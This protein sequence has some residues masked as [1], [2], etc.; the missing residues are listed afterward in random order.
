MTLAVDTGSPNAT[1]PASIDQSVAQLRSGARRLVTLSIPQRSSIIDRCIDGVSQVASQW[2]AAACQAKR[3]PQDSSAQS[4]EIIAGPFSTLRYL[5]LLKTTLNDIH[6][7]GQPQLPGRPSS[8]AG[9]LRVPIFPTR[10]LYDRLLFNPIQAETWIEPGVPEDE[11]F[12]GPATQLAGKAEP[13]P[14]RVATVLG[15]GNVSSIPATDALTKI[16]QENQAV[17]LKMNPVNAYLG[18]IFEQALSSLIEE[19]FLRIVYGA[20]DVGAYVVHHDQIDE[21]HI[22]GSNDAHD[23]IVWG[24]DADERRQRNDPVL[25]KPITSELGNVTPWAIVPG[26]YSDAQLRFQAENIVASIANNA[27]FNCIATKVL[28]TSRRW[29]DRQRFLDLIESIFGDVP[30]RYAYYPGATKR[31]T[32]FA[33]RDVDRS[34]AEYLPWTLL[35]DVDPDEAPQLFQRES[36]VCVVAETALDASSGEEFLSQSIDFMN[37][38]LWGTLAAA[39]TI[40]DEVRRQQVLFDDALSRLRYGTIG[41][42]QWPGVAYGLMSPPWGGFPGSDLH[43]VQSGRGT[44]HN[45]Y[46]LGRPEKTVLTSPLTVFPKPMWFSTHRRSEAV[47]WKL[48]ELYRDPSL[49]RLPGLL[50][51]AVLG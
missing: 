18:P 23:A 15:A 8:R 41:V 20:A 27:S 13:G 40:P 43:D 31:F 44:V 17:L 2:V 22:T 7:Y 12:D 3:I 29:P 46:L 21:V 10:D 26:R 30:R 48:L 32:E 14:P 19:S 45:T 49:R 4:E 28:V 39:L 35:R 42:N 34:W 37:K 50:F 33:G 9:Q 38:R 1:S 16:L 5:R 47:A 51:S 25:I 11:I 36:F 24:S 6:R